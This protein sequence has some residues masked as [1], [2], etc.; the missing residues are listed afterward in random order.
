M[1]NGVCTNRVCFLLF[2]AVSVVFG[3]RYQA[4][5][6]ELETIFERRLTGLDVR[7]HNEEVKT[8]QLESIIQ[9]HQK[10]IDRFNDKVTTKD[11]NDKMDLIEKEFADTSDSIEKKLAA[12]TDSIEKELTATT[13][14]I[15]GELAVTTEAL[16]KDMADTTRN[17]E[18][19]LNV[20]TRNIGKELDDTT[21]NLENQ[22]ANTTTTMNSQIAN[23]DAEVKKELSITMHEFNVIVTK[24]E[25][26]IHEDVDTVKKDVESYVRTTQ[27]QFSMENSFMKYQ[28]AM[29]FMLLSCLISMWHMTAHLRK[30]KEPVVQRKI[31]AILWMCPVYAITSWLSLIFHQAEPYLAVLRDFYEAYIIYQFL[32]F[33][34][35][36]LGRGDRE[37]VIDILVKRVEHLTPPFRLDGF[38]NPNPYDCDRALA[39]A[40]L[41]QCQGFAMQFVFF[42]PLTTVLLFMLEESHYG[43]PSGSVWDYRSP[44]LYITGIQNISVFIAFTGL[45]KF[46]HAVDKELAWCRPFAKFLCIKGVVFMTFWQGLAISMLAS[47][48][49]GDDQEKWAQSTQ[50]FLL[51][52]EMLL[53][54]IAHFYSFPT[55][56]WQEGYRAIHE[57][58]SRFG[59]TIA[60]GDFFQDL[61]LIMSNKKKPKD[62]DDSDKGAILEEDSS[63]EAYCKDVSVTEF[64]QALESADDDTVDKIS[65]MADL[66]LHE[67]IGI[68]RERDSSWQSLD[69][70]KNS[71]E[72]S[73]QKIPERRS[74]L[75]NNKLKKFY[76]EG[77]QDVDVECGVSSEVKAEVTKQSD[78]TWSVNISSAEGNDARNAQST[79][80]EDESNDTDDESGES[81]NKQSDETE[82]HRDTKPESSDQS[83]PQ[84]DESNGVD[85]E[86]GKDPKER[87]NSF[88]KQNDEAQDH[89]D[90]KPE[91][92]YQSKPQNDESHDVDEESG[93][94]SK[95]RIDS[96]KQSDE[97]QDHQDTEPECSD[98]SKPQNDESNDV[99]EESGEDSKK[100]TDS[101]KQS[102][103][104]QEHQDTEPESSD[105]SKPANDESNHADGEDSEKRMDSMRQSDEAQDHQDTKLKSTDQSRSHNEEILRP[106]IFT[107]LGK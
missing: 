14:N 65:Q 30:F 49:N 21:R 63:T 62:G 18:Q 86:S 29:T 47:S 57:K 50:N 43:S 73:E 22:L 46:Y 80:M 71:V 69:I 24:A 28:L 9:E 90:T 74:L 106:S 97:T 66:L 85:E 40:V 93:E 34:I 92:S 17:I 25:K 55:A 102:D 58:Q 54:S 19:D 60:L 12:T 78:V 26:Q 10:I 38:C 95:E 87:T 104:T 44:K 42:R 16:E 82:D 61:K 32:S 39:E 11:L 77:S 5:L 75:G 107:S 8:A 48:T 20:T 103:E 2:L 53:F 100:Q 6:I 1:K 98:Q 13:E 33:C 89:Q 23:L 31:L 37:A 51:C 41:L 76:G 45:L 70:T 81:S 35:C 56:E 84:N 15:E 101:V 59:D 7:L 72:A 96:F 91:R 36:V 94:D 83:T 3:I 64:Q 88:L 79:K 52:L 4:S 99:D 27:D 105:Q 68:L 67:E